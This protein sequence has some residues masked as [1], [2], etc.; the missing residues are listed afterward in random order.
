[1]VL[2]I[3]VTDA[4]A[5]QAQRINQA[6]VKELKDFVTE[7]E[8]PPGK[9]TPLL[10]GTLVDT[11][12]LPTSPVSPNPVRNLGLALVLGL[13]LGFGLAVLRELLD[14]SVKSIE[15]VPALAEVPVL[16][17]LA[18]DNDVQRAPADQHAALARR[19][20]GVL[21][22]AAHQP[23]LHRRRPGHQGLRGDQLGPRGGQVDHRGEHRDRD[24]QRRSEHAAHRR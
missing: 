9:S 1:M 19:P 3:T 8:T 11:P 22:G 24:G 18:Y 2:K 7:L 21:P 14:T 20:G 5:R 4:N 23:V 12:R 6:V 13:L 16:G 10:K 17:G 15:D